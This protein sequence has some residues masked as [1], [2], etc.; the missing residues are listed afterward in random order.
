[1]KDTTRI[2]VIHVVCLLYDTPKET[3][4]AMEKI[5]KDKVA[6]D[7]LKYCLKEKMGFLKMKEITNTRTVQI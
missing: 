3:I 6:Y 2:I 5:D 1:M 7:R 4:K